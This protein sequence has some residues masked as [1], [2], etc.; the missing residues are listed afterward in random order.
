MDYKLIKERVYT[1]FSDMTN[2]S[3]KTISEITTALQL[4][5]EEYKRLKYNA[6]KHTVTKILTDIT[7]DKNRT[8]F[9]R[10]DILKPRN[11]LIY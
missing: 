3:F 8:I 6:L 4:K 2:D 5:Y 7:Q 1:L 9:N 11:V 10:N